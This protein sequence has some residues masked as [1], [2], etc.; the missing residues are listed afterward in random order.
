MADQLPLIKQAMADIK[1]GKYTPTVAA[2]IAAGGI[3]EQQVDPFTGQPATV[4]ISPT[5]E[6][7]SNSEVITVPKDV[8]DGTSDDGNAEQVVAN[9]DLPPEEAKAEKKEAGGDAKP[10]KKEGGGDAKPEKKEGDA[11]PEKKDDKAPP[12]EAKKATEAA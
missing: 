4:I 5:N 1:A 9:D 6:L 7:V 12:A 11:K 8:K 3:V 10:A 2:R